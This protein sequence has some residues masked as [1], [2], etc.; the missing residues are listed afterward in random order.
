MHLYFLS[1]THELHK[2][3]KVRMESIEGATRN[4]RTSDEG[5]IVIMSKRA[6]LPVLLS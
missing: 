3:N 1:K 4:Y 2:I 6:N 5:I